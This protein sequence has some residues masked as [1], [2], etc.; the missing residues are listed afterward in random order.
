[1]WKKKLSA[2]LPSSHWPTN[3]YASGL[4][5]VNRVLEV[6]MDTVHMYDKVNPTDDL[7]KKQKHTLIRHITNSYGKYQKRLT[8]LIYWFEKMK[9]TLNPLQKTGGSVSVKIFN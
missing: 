4:K 5:D 6:T 1:M 3:A 7:N 8:D 2:P 9:E